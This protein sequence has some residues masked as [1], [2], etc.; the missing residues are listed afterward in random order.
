LA[1]ERL[2]TICRVFPKVGLSMTGAALRDGAV[3]FGFEGAKFVLK[4]FHMK[5]F[6]KD[7]FRDFGVDGGPWPTKD[8]AFSEREKALVK[9][10]FRLARVADEPDSKHARMY[11]EEAIAWYQFHCNQGVPWIIN[12]SPK[13]L[14]EAEFGWPAAFLVLYCSAEFRNLPQDIKKIIVRMVSWRSTYF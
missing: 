3:V 9:T 4:D 5:S 2:A 13:M 6:R 10:H 14:F 7:Q 1:Q 12:I 8:L 11:R